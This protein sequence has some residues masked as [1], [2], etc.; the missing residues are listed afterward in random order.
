MSKRLTTSDCVVLLERVFG[1]INSWMAI[2]LTFA[3]RLQLIPLV[4]C[5]SIFILHKYI[6]KL[7]EQKV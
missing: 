4:Y 3:A 7:L 2:K 5:S 1:L 6:I